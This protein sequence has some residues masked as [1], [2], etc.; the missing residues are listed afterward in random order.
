M[1][2]DDWASLLVSCPVG[3][4]FLLTIQRDQEPV[5]SA[6]TPPQAFARFAVAKDVVNPWSETFDQDAKALL[7]RGPHLTDLARETLASPESR[8]W[9]A[10]FDRSRQ[11]FIVEEGDDQ[12][13]D[14]PANAKWEAYAERPTACRVTSTLRGE[15]SCLDTIIASGIGD[16]PSGPWRRSRAQID[17]SARV[18]EVRNPAD[19]HGLCVSHSRINQHANSPAGVGVLTPDWAGV[20]TQWDGIHLTFM[21]LLTVPFVRYNS[22][23]GT[24]MMW[25][26]DTEAT[27]WLPGEFLRPG[28]PLAPVG[29]E[30]DRFALVAPLKY[31]DLGT[32]PKGKIYR[33]K[34][35]RPWWLRIIDNAR[36]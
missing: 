34:K 35:R 33:Y 23:A 17:G 7:A 30:V 19:W 9:T 16:W 15:Y 21:A 2:T 32:R 20:A 26:W 10:P 8:W 31:S 1:G 13:P 14:T 12:Q 6:V 29:R 3:C 28:T 18:L 4:A 11:V 5:A 25:A 24:T 27:I 36:R 22:A